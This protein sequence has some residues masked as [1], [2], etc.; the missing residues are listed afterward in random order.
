M[1]HRTAID[2][3]VRA[4]ENVVPVA[5]EADS[6]HPVP[7]LLCPLDVCYISSVSSQPRGEL[8][9]ATVGNGGSVVVTTVLG[10][11]LP[12]EAAIAHCRIPAGGHVVENICS[13]FDPRGLG[14][15]R[16]GILGG[17]HSR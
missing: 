12:F 1:V 2:R 11:D 14:W 5:D 7:R 4:V 8:E 6:S 3:V 15:V 13:K 10:K 16:I 9:E 17:G